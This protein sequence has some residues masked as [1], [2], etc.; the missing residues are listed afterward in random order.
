MLGHVF[1]SPASRDIN[2]GVGDTLFREKPETD[3]ILSL[4][5]PLL[6]GEIDIGLGAKIVQNPSRHEL[7]HHMI[8]CQKAS[9]S[10]DKKASTVDLNSSVPLNAYYS[11]HG[12]FHSINRIDERVIAALGDGDAETKINANGTEDENERTTN[13]FSTNQVRPFSD[14]CN[15]ISQN[16]VWNVQ[17]PAEIDELHRVVLPPFMSK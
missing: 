11:S 13:N 8:S 15:T 4:S 3:N 10:I 9:D 1:N 5:C 2:Q 17:C 14:R 16:G 7:S 6:H 12:L